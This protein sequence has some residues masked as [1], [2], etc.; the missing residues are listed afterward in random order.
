MT[1]SSPRRGATGLMLIELVVSVVLVAV[2]GAVSLD[3]KRIRLHVRLVRAQKSGWA[4][5]DT[6]MLGLQVTSVEPYAWF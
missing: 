2:L 3:R 6:A 5:E 4:S 1:S